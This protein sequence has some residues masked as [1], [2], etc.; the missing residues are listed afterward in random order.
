MNDQYNIIVYDRQ[1][2][3]Q[4]PDFWTLVE[5]CSTAINGIIMYKIAI[6]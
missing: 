4:C 5:G 1:K 2:N 3:L 6:I